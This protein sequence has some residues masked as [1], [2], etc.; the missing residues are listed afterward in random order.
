MHKP[1][2]ECFTQ[3]LLILWGLLSHKTKTHDHPTM[4]NMS[5]MLILFLCV[6]CLIFVKH[7][8]KTFKQLQEVLE[9]AK[10]AIRIRISVVYGHRQSHICGG[11]AM[12]WSYRKWS[13]AHAWPDVTSTAL[14]VRDWKWPK[15]KWPRRGALGCA[16]AQ[17]EVG[18]SHPFLGFGFPVLFSGFFWYDVTRQ[19][20]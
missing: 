6:I 8:Q 11:E 20:K 3:F 14:T 4:C 15:V 12:R 16:H 17:P 10:G 1:N 5:D 18:V 19:K 9:D 7:P 2:C 13:R